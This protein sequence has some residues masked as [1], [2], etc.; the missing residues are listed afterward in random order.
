MSTSTNA[1][2]MAPT[3]WAIAPGKESSRAREPPI[4][5]IEHP[6]RRNISRYCFFAAESPTKAEHVGAQNRLK[7]MFKVAG[8]QFYQDA[9]Q[10]MSVGTEVLMVRDEENLSDPSAFAIVTRT[11]RRLVGHIFRKDKM[12]ATGGARVPP[13]VAQARQCQGWGDDQRRKNPRSM[14]STNTATI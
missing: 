2:S 10:T 8:V 11:D 4:L 1:S 14:P 9:V 7:R 13:P 3:K 6:A 5:A 12:D